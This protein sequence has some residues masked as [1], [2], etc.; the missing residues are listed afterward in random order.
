MHPRVCLLIARLRAQS[1]E[2]LNHKNIHSLFLSREYKL[3]GRVCKHLR[4]AGR[5]IRTLSSP[6]ASRE[7]SALFTSPHSLLH[8][9][10]N[11]SLGHLPLL[12]IQTK[13]YVEQ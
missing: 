4:P 11:Q 10:I 8:S 2:P 1:L 6:P 3:L 13:G 9:G 7:L 5:V 12:G